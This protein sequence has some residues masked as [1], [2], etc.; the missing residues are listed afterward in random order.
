LA[1]RYHGRAAV[2]AKS[3]LYGNLIAA[4]LAGVHLNIPFAL[5]RR[6]ARK[7]NRAPLN[8]Y[9]QRQPAHKAMDGRHLHGPL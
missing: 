1:L 3:L 5:T 4:F 6:C 8:P 2:R 7:L 9:C